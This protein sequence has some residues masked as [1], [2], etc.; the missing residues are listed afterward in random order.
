[1]YARPQENGNRTD[2]RW[3]SFTNKNGMNLKFVGKE[4]FNFSASH[5]KRKD[6]DSGKSKKTSQKHGRLL[7][8]R[9][10]IFI[11]IDGFTSGVG[12]VDSWG[13]LPR[14]EYLLPYGSYNYSYWIVPM[15][16]DK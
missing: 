6:L 1:M 13:T 12:G 15:L 4:L 16:N 14:E 5:F 10:E 3:V 11:N 2:V 8:P 7:N 9:N